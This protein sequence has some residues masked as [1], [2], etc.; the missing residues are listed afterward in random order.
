MGIKLQ[1]GNNSTNLANVSSLNELKVVTPITGV[2]AGFISASTE[3]DSGDDTGYRTVIVLDR[4]DD[5][6]LRVG[7]DQSVFNAT[8]EGTVLQTPIWFQSL[9]TMTT[10]VVNGFVILNAGISTASGTVAY[11]RT[12]RL[13][14]TWGT[15]PTYVDM[16]VREANQDSVNSLSEWGL[17]YTV[18]SGTQQLTDGIYFR[19]LSGGQLKAIITNNSID[20]AEQGIDTTGIPPRNLVGSYDPTESNHYLISYHNDVV[21]FWINDALVAELK[22]PSAQAMFTSSSNVPVGFRVL[23]LAATSTAR[24]LSV[25]YVNVGLGDQN[26]NKPWSN[27]LC[28]AGQGAYQTQ[29]GSAVGPTVT[30]S[31]ATTGHPASGTGRSTLTWSATTG[32]GLN[33]L[34]GLWT[35]PAISTLS[36]DA[37]YPIF[38]FL[39]PVGTA[40]I[41]GKTLYVTGIRIGETSATV[42]AATNGIFLSFIALVE[43]SSSILP[44]SDSATNTSGKS[45]VLGGQGFSATDVAGTTKPG[46]DISFNS[47]LVIPSGKYLHIVV[48]PFGTVTLNT[49]VVTGSVAVNGYFE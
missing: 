19:R 17:I 33:N 15:Y 7:L 1:G 38:A 40:A 2:C 35:S 16:W 29:Q 37:D 20:I 32:P 5:S 36:A 28:G 8:F 11:I 41:T 21:R 42:A 46:F 45:I 47:P 10:Q 27:A 39:N 26:T 48:R 49:L 22:C 6:R 25:G 43:A 31:A 23:N 18:S 3:V 30:R 4:L 9:S 14:P 34:G 24:Q 12:Y 13:F 44:G